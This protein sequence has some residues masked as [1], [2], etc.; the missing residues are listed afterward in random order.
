MLQNLYFLFWKD[1]LKSRQHHKSYKNPIE[2]LMI[3]FYGIFYMFRVH[4]ACGEV[5]KSEMVELESACSREDSD[6]SSSEASTV[7]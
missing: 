1:F 3:E 2:P 7:S 5:S 6:S 4:A